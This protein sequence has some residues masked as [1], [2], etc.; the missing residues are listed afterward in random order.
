MTIF[1]QNPEGRK[2]LS[3][4]TPMSEDG[5]G[6]GCT[7]SDTGLISVKRYIFET[8]KDILKL[9]L[10]FRLNYKIYL[11]VNNFD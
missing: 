4:A 8:D 5:K 10:K 7:L 11:S 1:L 3:H 2:F 6:G 9:K